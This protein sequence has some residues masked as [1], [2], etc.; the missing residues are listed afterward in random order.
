MWPDP[1]SHGRRVRAAAAALGGD[2]AVVQGFLGGG[3][4]PE[5][6]IPAEAVVLPQ[7]DA[8][9]ARL[10]EGEPAVVAYQKD[11]RLVLDLRTVEP[12]DDADLISAVAA[13]RQGA[14]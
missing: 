10:R 2:I 11:G 3:S 8:L 1:E 13:A 5:L 12:G 7:D 4:A 6:G 14:G 9:L